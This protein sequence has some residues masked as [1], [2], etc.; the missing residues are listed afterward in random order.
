MVKDLPFHPDYFERALPYILFHGSY[1][2]VIGDI[3][4]TDIIVTPILS[5]SLEKN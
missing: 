4:L 5:S 2:T 1:L 3:K